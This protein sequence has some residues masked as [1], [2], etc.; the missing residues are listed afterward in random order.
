MV[1]PW[2]EIVAK[3]EGAEATVTA[4]IDLRKVEEMRKE[5]E[6]SLLE[7]KETMICMK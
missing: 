2:A 6:Y 5:K 4:E 7:A 1:S 3:C